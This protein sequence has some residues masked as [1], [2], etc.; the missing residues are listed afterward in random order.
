MSM[1]WINTFKKRAERTD[2]ESIMKK[3]LWEEAEKSINGE[4]RSRRD[5]SLLA[6]RRWFT[7]LCKVE[8]PGY[9]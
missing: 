4:T 1:S 8:L 2:G 6:V 3:K 9:S 5:P 7:K